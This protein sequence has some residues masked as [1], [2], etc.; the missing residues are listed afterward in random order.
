MLGYI[1]RLRNE[2]KKN[3]KTRKTHGAFDA[4]TFL[5]KFPLLTREFAGRIRQ[6][7]NLVCTIQDTYT[8]RSVLPRIMQVLIC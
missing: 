7:F 8:V 1:Y 4:A 2:Q 5:I 6:E 3:K